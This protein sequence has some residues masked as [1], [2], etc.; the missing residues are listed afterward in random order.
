MNKLTKMGKINKNIWNNHQI[1]EKMICYN[2]KNIS[3][4]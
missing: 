3:K 4:T 1:N 2:R